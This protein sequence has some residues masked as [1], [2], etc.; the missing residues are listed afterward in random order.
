M[1]LLTGA[2]VLG[3]HATRAMFLKTDDD[4]ADAENIFPVASNQ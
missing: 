2:T 1:V 3:R 4:L